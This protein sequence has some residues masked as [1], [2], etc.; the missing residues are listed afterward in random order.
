MVGREITDLFPRKSSK[1]GPPVL[2]VESLNVADPY[3]GEVSFRFSFSLQAGEVLGIGGL[4]ERSHRAIDA[5][6]RRVG[7]RKSGA[8]RLDNQELRARKPD[9]IIRHGL[10]LVSEDR[11][12][13]GLIWTNHRL[14]SSL[15]S[16]ANLTSNRLID[17]GLEFKRNN[18]FFPIAA[19]KSAD[20]GGPGRQALWRQPTED[21]FWARPS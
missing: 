15:S 10:V 8:V 12:R 7:E 6:V 20:H 2:Q 18:R 3:S 14:Q 1:P 17:Q 13:Y 16:L 11:R 4:M 5:F 21:C 9:E 19:R